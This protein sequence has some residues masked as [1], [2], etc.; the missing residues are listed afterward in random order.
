MRIP[1]TT[2]YDSCRKIWVDV[3]FEVTVLNNQSKFCVGAFG[4]YYWVVLANQNKCESLQFSNPWPCERARQQTRRPSRSRHCFTTAVVKRNGS[5]DPIRS[6]RGKILL[7]KKILT[8]LV[9]SDIFPAL[10]T[11]LRPVI[12]FCM[13]ERDGFPFSMRL[14]LLCCWILTFFIDYMYCSLVLLFFVSIFPFVVVFFYQIGIFFCVDFCVFLTRM[15]LV[16]L[17]LVLV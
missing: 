6:P 7:A 8:N 3:L 17:L 5:H 1:L 9:P 14:P 4:L 15:V 11:N 10:P 16:I 13:A 2:I 12:I